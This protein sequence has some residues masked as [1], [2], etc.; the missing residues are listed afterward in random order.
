MGWSRVKV[1][2]FGVNHSEIF[3][4]SGLSPS[5]HFPRVLGIECTGILV[6][7]A[8]CDEAVLDQDGKLQTDK[9]YDKVLE[10][11]GPATLRDTFS[12]VREGGIVCSTGELGG[13]WNIDLEPIQD[14]PV[15]GYL[16]S[17]YSGN[18]SSEKRNEMLAF[19]ESHKGNVRPDRI[20]SFEEVPEAHRWLESRNG[21]GKAVALL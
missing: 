4:R 3:T 21:H 10:L 18:V 6:K 19:I 1:H 17:F 2:G 12:H 11:I 15:N 8:G 5:V 13:V 14:L 16:T 7:Q 20:F 9:C